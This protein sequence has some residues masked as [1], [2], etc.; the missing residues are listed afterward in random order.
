LSQDLR[1]GNT[2]HPVFSPLFIDWLQESWLLCSLK[3]KMTHITTGAMILALLSNPNR[4][5]RM[6]YFDLL[7][8]ISL[9]KLFNLLQGNLS[10][11]N[12][13]EQSST[14]T[15]ET[16]NSTENA[17]KKYTV[18]FTLQAKSGEIDPVFCRDNE[19]RQIIDVLA[20]RRKN[21]PIAVG[22]PGVGKTG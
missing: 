13:G 19:I 10:E 11:Q 3:L 4:F 20:R 22:E 15:S 21:N 7:E 2:S 16:L 6:A 14:A 5:G 8:A 17:L 9:E 12:Q 1:S 18:D